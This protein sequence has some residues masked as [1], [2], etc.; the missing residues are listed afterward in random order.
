MK[1]LL[2]ASLICCVL[3]TP[4]LACAQANDEPSRWANVPADPTLTSQTPANAGTTLGEDFLGI[5][6]LLAQA[7][8]DEVYASLMRG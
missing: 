8:E 1:A 6:D 2:Q 7:Y 5:E 4:T 3:G